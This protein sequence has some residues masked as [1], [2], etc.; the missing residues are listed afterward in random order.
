MGRTLAFLSGIAFTGF[1][2]TA[3]PAAWFDEYKN[4]W[5]WRKPA[6]VTP[7][8]TPS[9]PPSDAV[10]LFDGKDLSAFEGGEAWLVENGAATVRG[11][12]LKTK[13]KFGSCQLHVEFA[14]PEKAEG[15]GQGRGNSGI[16]FMSQYEVQVLD[17]YEN[18]TYYDG[19]CASIY[20]QTPPI[21]NASKKPGQWQTYDIIFDAPEFD[22]DGKVKKPAYMT[23]LHNGV[24]VQN[25]FELTGM[26]AYEHA[27]KYVPH[28]AKL[29]IHIQNHGNPVRYRNIWIRE[30]VAAPIPKKPEVKVEG[31]SEAKPAP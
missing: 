30:N 21:V 27:P 8:E 25:H 29:P 7:G 5:I 19:Q 3:A 24:L 28:E 16:Y 1:L 20:K 14:T 15:G 22:A 2:L 4:G 6:L 17:S 9:A 23:V 13:Q 12:S 10:I 31:S 18:E 11:A 26:T